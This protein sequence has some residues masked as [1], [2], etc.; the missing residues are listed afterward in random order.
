MTTDQFTLGEYIRRLR[1][2]ANRNLHSVSEETR[3][4][5]SH[6]SRIEN[7]ST[8]PSADTVAR[9][10][11]ALDG[12]LKMMLEMADCLP[13][14]ILDRIAARE[15]VRSPSSLGRALAHK[16]NRAA[17]PSELGAAVTDLALAAGLDEN[18]VSDILEAVSHLIRL[19]PA[20]RSTLTS[21][22]RSLYEDRH[23]QSS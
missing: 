17:Q 9:I 16:P 4:S 19:G 10:A 6:L 13:R 3:I 20:R 23:E 14:T 18:E 21:L 12:D 11:T 7:D 2:Q 15:E 5:Y 1:R 8:V 22:I